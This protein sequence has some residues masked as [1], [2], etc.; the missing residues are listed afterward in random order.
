MTTSHLTKAADASPARDLLYA[1]RY[2]LGG[3]R[4]VLVLAVI[5]ALIGVGFN[6]SW[7]V[8]AG[9][10]PI[11]ISIL[12]C[13]VMCGLG[14]CMMCR[15]SGEQSASLRDAADPATSPVALAVAKT[16][17]LSA[18]AAACCHEQTEATRPPEVTQLQTIDERRR[19]NA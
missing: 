13:L 17:H 3:W 8:A 9:I 10:A 15:S 14:F 1:A 4:G 11:L 12:P 19:S 18:S 6:W 7:L 5:A 2:Y 16:D